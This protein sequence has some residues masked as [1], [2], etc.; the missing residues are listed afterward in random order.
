MTILGER[1]RLIALGGPS[2]PILSGIRDLETN[3]SYDPTP[4]ASSRS[5]TGERSRHLDSCAGRR[6]GDFRFLFTPPRQKTP[7]REYSRSAPRPPPTER[8]QP[9]RSRFLG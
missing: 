6:S 4:P 3:T 8:R 9:R 1:Q 7:I 5:R 2:R